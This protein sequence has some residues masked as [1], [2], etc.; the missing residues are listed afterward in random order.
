MSVVYQVVIPNK[1]SMTQK[2]LM[3]ELSETN[4][5]DDPLFKEFKKYL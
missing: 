1:L 3:K 5:E 4:L 2:R